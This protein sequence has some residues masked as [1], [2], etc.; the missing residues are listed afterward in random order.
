MIVADT[1]GIYAL[2]D[3]GDRH[4]EAARI[5]LESTSEP[6]IV[7]L[8]VVAEV[9]YFLTR[10]LGVDAA[11]DFLD[12]LRSGAF[13][14]DHLKT[15]DLDFC[16]KLIKQYQDLALGFVDASVLAVAERLGTRTILTLDHRDFRA[17]GSNSHGPLVLYPADL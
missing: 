9:D 4:H 5:I 2:Y 10:Y 17:V 14:L 8:P 13:A 6:L 3:A 16:Y 15:G 7:P 12:S 1:G 11:L